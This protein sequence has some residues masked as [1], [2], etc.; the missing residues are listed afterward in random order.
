[1]IRKH[2][3][4]NKKREDVIQTW[5]KNKTRYSYF[6]L[7][8]KAR[9]Y[10]EFYAATQ[11][12]ARTGWNTQMGINLLVTANHLNVVVSNGDTKQY[13]TLDKFLDTMQ[14]TAPP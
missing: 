14:Q 4:T 2:V 8:V 1:M 10:A 7:S 12:N 9:A 6:T 5:K 13:M 3:K 11:R